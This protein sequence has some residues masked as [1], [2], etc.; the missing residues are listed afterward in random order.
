[1]GPVCVNVSVL[2]GVALGIQTGLNYLGLGVNPPA[3]SWGGLVADAQGYLEQQP[4]LI[5]PSG[6]V[7]ALTILSF[8]LIGDALRDVLGLHSSSLRAV[9][10]EGVTQP[11]LPETVHQLVSN[12]EGATLLVRGLSVSYGAK[13]T[14]Q[15]R[16]IQDVAF[17]LS[18][19]EIVGVV[20]ESGSGK[21]VAALAILGLL[22]PGGEI[23]HGECILEGQDL[24]AMSDAERKNVRG[25][26]IAYVSQ[27]PMTALDQCY[28]I[29]SQLRELVRLHEPRLGRHE[30]SARVSELLNQVGLPNADEVG[31]K[32]PHQI[33]GG[34][35]QRVCIAAAL[36][37]RPKL[38][39]ADEPTT[40]LDVTIQAEILDLLR[41]IR[42]ETGMAVLLITHD[43]GVVADV[44]DRAVVM[45]AGE[46]VEFGSVR[47]VMR[48]PL[49]PYTKALIAANPTFA[50]R[51]E[52]LQTIPGAIITPLEWP[53][54]CHFANRCSYRI[55]TCTVAPIPLVVVG[56]AHFSRCPVLVNIRGSRDGI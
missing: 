11:L 46:V 50:V 48:S 31:R 28:T 13:G 41:T 53:V 42:D 44:C 19:G 27:E 10:S 17:D 18:P 22:G 43:L 45:Y 2:A 14:T 5:V 16:V 7:V 23:L 9:G 49:H 21:T 52:E 35:A 8:V 4:W 37:G 15:I 38:L 47:Q 6:L 29:F 12:R 1:M 30:V 26:G 39:V 24:V 55:D 20:G 34:M 36:A 32:Y 25:S 33:S 56:E 40:A 54:G 51:G 3:P